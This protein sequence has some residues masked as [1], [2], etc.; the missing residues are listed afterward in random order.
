MQAAF[1]LL[2][3]FVACWLAYVL[4]VH[5]HLEVGLDH[6]WGRRYVWSL[7]RVCLEPAV[8]LLDAQE[9]RFTYSRRSPRY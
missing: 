4:Q 3:A 2:R 5:T 1:A 9:L 8:R 7:R 6:R